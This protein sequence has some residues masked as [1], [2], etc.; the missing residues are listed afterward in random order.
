MDFV[1]HVIDY[2]FSGIRALQEGLPKLG[3]NMDNFWY[4]YSLN[5]YIKVSQA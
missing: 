4:Y 1:I 5:V 3:N 2:L